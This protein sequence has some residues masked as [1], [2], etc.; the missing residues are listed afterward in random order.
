MRKQYQTA[1]SV[2]KRSHSD[3]FADYQSSAAKD[4]IISYL[5][6]NTEKNLKNKS[7]QINIQLLDKHWKCD[8]KNLCIQYLDDLP[9]PTSISQ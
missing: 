7:K 8:F 9:N 5:D 2:S 4:E 6:S 1:V 3:A